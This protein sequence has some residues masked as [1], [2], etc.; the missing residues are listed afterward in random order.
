M[1]VCTCLCLCV[2]GYRLDGS[3][4]VPLK[5][6]YRSFIAWLCIFIELAYISRYRGRF[7]FQTWLIS[8]LKRL[9]SL[10]DGWREKQTNH[11]HFLRC[12]HR[13]LLLTIGDRYWHGIVSSHRTVNVI[14]FY[15]FCFVGL[16]WAVWRC[17]WCWWEPNGKTFSLWSDC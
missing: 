2:F 11:Y 16:C 12:H 15:G 1:P 5:H 14:D 13:H 17:Y 10:V 9:K 6:F 8:W 4:F 3:V 7:F